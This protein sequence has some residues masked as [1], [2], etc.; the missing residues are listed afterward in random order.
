MLSFAQDTVDGPKERK[1]KMPTSKIAQ[2]RACVKQL[3]YEISKHETMQPM[4]LSAVRFHRFGSFFVSNFIIVPWRRFTE[5]FCFFFI[6]YKCYRIDAFRLEKKE[7]IG[8]R[9]CLCE[10]NKIDFFFIS[11]HHRVRHHLKKI[12][13]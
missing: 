8:A 5:L 10:L 2:N 1:K 6:H 11:G 12:V 4:A 9:C 13:I 3:K 7:K